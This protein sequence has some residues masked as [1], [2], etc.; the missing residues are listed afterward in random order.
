[1]VVTVG[2]CEIERHGASEVDGELRAGLRVGEFGLVDV[3]LVGGIDKGCEAAELTH[4]GAG[5][6][7]GISCVVAG[8]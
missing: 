8:N 6:C 5:L 2:G 7:Q 1:M 3:G 4:V